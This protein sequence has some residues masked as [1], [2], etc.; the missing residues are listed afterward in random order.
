MVL[1]YYGENISQDEVHTRSPA[2]EVMT[3]FL[4]EF[5]DCELVVNF[6][7][8][9]LK[10]EVSQGNPVMVR[11]L[12][13]EYHHTIVIVGYDEIYLYTHDPDVGAFLKTNPEVL[14]KYW[15]P[16]EFAA[17]TCRAR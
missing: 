7:V 4:S 6:G 9:D 16:T 11:I 1:A 5:I 2:F 10:A 3:P 13:G 14:L 12:S 8:D 17:I 15:E